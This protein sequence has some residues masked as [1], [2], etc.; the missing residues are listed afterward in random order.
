MK[1]NTISLKEVIAKI[2]RHP[3]LTSISEDSIVEDTVDF[4]RIMNLCETFEDKIVTLELDKYRAIL[5]DD[6]YDVVQVRT[7]PPKPNLPP[8]YFRSTTDN[9]YKSEN[10]YH[11]VPYTYKIQGNIIY[12]SPM[13]T[14]KIEVAYK[15][16]E[17]DDCGLPAIPDNAHFTRALEAYIKVRYFTILF[18]LGQISGQSLQNAQQEYSWAVASLHTAMK[19]PSI[20]EME[21]VSNML[22]S[23]VGVRNTH[24]RGYA[25]SGNKEFYRVH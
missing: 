11:K 16:L 15:A 6:F 20:D 19:M 2:K 24:H 18:D 23:L 8:I 1:P 22:N 4:L 7:V 13:K 17:M 9:F 12:C 10:N 5:P 3:L 25:D 14:G 21:S